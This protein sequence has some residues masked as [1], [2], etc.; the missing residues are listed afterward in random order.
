MLVQH[1]VPCK[2]SLLEAIEAATKAT[3][4]VWFVRRLETLRLVDVD[5]LLEFCLEEGG[6][7][8]HLVDREIPS[9]VAYT[10]RR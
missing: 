5:D 10:R 3:D 7:N 6:H 2:C 4:M 9:T 1:L 8:I